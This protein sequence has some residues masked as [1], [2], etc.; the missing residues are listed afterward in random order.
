MLAGHARGGKGRFAPPLSVVPSSPPSPRIEYCAEE[1]RHERRK[2]GHEDED[3]GVG[4]DGERGE[5]KRPRERE[6]R[7]DDYSEEKITAMKVL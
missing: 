2:R 3:R 4:S 7:R 5:A 6:D 1:S